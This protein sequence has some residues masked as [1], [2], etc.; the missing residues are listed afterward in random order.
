MNKRQKETQQVFL[1]NEKAVLKKLEGNYQDALDEINSKIELLMARQ[2]ADMQHVIY[3]VEYQKALKTQVQSILETLQTNEFETVAEYLAKSY[4]DGFIGAMYD[5]HG[6]GIPL[7]FPID[8]A[9]VVAAIQHETNLTSNLY[10]EMGHD[11][12]DLQKKIAGEI[13]RGISGGQMYG[14]ITRNI[15]SWARIPRNR[16]VTIARTEAHRIQTKAAMD[17]QYKAKDK[18]ADV[19]KQ[20]DASLDGKTRDSHRQVDGEFRELDEPFSNG[21]MYPGDPSGRPE[22]VINCR[23]AL[24]QRARWALGN[25]YTKWSA[26]APVVVD[27]EGTTQ[28]AI[29]EAKNYEDFKK[30]YKQ[31]SERVR[32]DAQKMKPV[33]KNGEEIQFDFKG[34]GERHEQQKQ[35]ITELSNQYNT[36]LQKVTIGA[37]NGAGDVDMSGTIMRLSG[38]QVDAAIHEFAHTLANA[39]ADKYGL[40]N[41][42]AFWNE[43]KKIR[44]EY[45]KVVKDDTYRFISTYE[46]GE[47]KAPLDEFLAEAFTQAKMNEMGL[48]IPS[49]YGSDLTYSKQVLEVVDKYFGKK[50]LENIGKSSKIVSGAVSGA[51]N[52]YGEKA[53]EH[54]Q[55]YYGLVRSMKTDVAKISKATGIAEEDVQAVKNFIFLEKH[56]LG[57]KELEYFEPDYMMAESWQRL[58]EGK[59]ESHDI[60]LI[61][62]EIMER[63][64]MAE[65][66]S[67]ED[68]HIQTSKKYNYSKEA[69]DYYAKIEKYK[70]D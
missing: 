23:C 29:I 52:P 8:Q 45:R 18:G 32:E 69:G 16:A 26:D 2:D 51:R 57:G 59:P 22:E 39:S 35:I 20:W 19:V 49:K 5:M 33:N 47:R 1:D 61:K 48:E 37:K 13:S 50:P 70:E 41:D 34:K 24:L 53:K 56:D 31:A 62:H 60:T 3:Q 10:T 30:K 27:D 64:L 14:E 55:K 54:A 11:I 28:F 66:L 7:I 67:Q 40:T 15:A 58:V 68:A 38:S 43:I 21:L 46:H 36:R 63:R 65:G 42:S 9:Q 6:Q 4:D 12:K 17:A 44:T 25:D